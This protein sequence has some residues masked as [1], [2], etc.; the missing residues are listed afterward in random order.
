[1]KRIF[2]E[3]NILSSEYSIPLNL[4]SV[5]PCKLL[6]SDYFAGMATNRIKAL[7]MTLVVLDR[8]KKHR[9]VLVD[10]VKRLVR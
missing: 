3:R 6:I 5:R 2:F 1:M 9:F 8:M 7:L 10:K 4:A